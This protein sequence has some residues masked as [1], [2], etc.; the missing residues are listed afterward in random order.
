MPVVTRGR[1][2]RPSCERPADDEAQ[3]SLALDAL[4]PTR[5]TPPLVPA[6]LRSPD[7]SAFGPIPALTAAPRYREM[8]HR[9][10]I[11]GL[12][13]LRDQ[14]ALTHKL[15]DAPPWKISTRGLLLGDRASPMATPRSCARL[16][17][18]ALVL[19]VDR[20]AASDRPAFCPLTEEGRMRWGRGSG[21]VMRVGAG[22]PGALADPRDAEGPRP[23]TI[24]CGS[25][26][27][28]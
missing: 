23:W 20:I 16:L 18:L 9:R 17:L 1:S 8:Q 5:Q 26:R 19:A 13:L 7:P 3:P 28:S 21:R 15:V 11:L 2:A 24:L 14:A 12:L 25:S 22:R 10:S 6:T 27:T 4:Q